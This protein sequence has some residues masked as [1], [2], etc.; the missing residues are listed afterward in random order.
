MKNNKNYREGQKSTN[1]LEKTVIHQKQLKKK[2]MRMTYQRKKT[3]YYQKWP[4]KNNYQ[5]GPS[6]KNAR[7]HWNNKKN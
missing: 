3:K 4:T 1:I 7:K 6:D 2:R 5:K